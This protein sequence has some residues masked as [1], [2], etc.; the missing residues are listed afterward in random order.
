MAIQRVSGS[1]SRDAKRKNGGECVTKAVKEE[2]YL[3]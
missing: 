1:E 2:E 3:Y